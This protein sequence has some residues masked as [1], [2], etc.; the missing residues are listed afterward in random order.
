V[1]EHVNLGPQ[2]D[3]GFVSETEVNYSDKKKNTTT[4]VDTTRNHN[5]HTSIPDATNNK[6][7]GPTGQMKHS[8]SLS[9]N[10]ERTH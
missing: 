3:I 4:D 9:P 1:Q 8:K 6:D 2:G 7:H 5:G 10:H